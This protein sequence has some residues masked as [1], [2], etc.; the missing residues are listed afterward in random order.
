MKVKQ[1]SEISTTKNDVL[2]FQR[3]APKILTFGFLGINT[4]TQNSDICEI[5][6]I[7]Q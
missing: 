6:S 4:E 7:Q 1:K 3:L 5:W 2:S